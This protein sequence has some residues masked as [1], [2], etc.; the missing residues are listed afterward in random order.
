MPARSRGFCY[1]C[2]AFSWFL[3]GCAP[4]V[5]NPRARGDDDEEEWPNVVDSFEMSIGPEL[6]P[7]SYLLTADQKLIGLPKQT[8]RIFCIGA[9][10]SADRV[11]FQVFLNGFRF[12]RG[13]SPVSIAVNPFTLVTSVDLSK[14][15]KA[16]IGGLLVFK[17]SFLTYDACYY[18]GVRSDEER[19]ELLAILS[20]TIQAVTKSLFPDHTISAAPIKKIPTTIDRLMAGYLLRLDWHES[21]SA[22]LLYAD[23]GIISN[24][25]ATFR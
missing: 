24:D 8:S 5:A 22:I 10:G 4:I 17:V 11:S 18:F 2:N 6:N 23:L 15:Q 13:S 21:Q 14:I 25:S 19:D 20:D 7:E 12:W 16:L 9:D 1:I 3:N